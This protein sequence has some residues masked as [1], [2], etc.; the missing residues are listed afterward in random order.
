MVPPIIPK[1]ILILV[2]P[3]NPNNLVIL[4]NSAHSENSDNPGLLFLYYTYK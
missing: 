4:V 2:H 3:V 1:L